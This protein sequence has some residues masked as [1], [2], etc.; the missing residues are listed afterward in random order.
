MLD[1]LLE[2]LRERFLLRPKARRMQLSFLL[3]QRQMPDMSTIDLKTCLILEMLSAGIPGAS[4]DY[5]S[6]GGLH[7]F[8]IS[9]EGLTYEL[10][11]IERLLNTSNLEDIRNALGLVID[12]VQT[13]AVPRRMKFGAMAARGAA[14]VDAS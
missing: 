7:R 13:R 10:S 8:L 9:S 6:S 5:E 4:F 11:F 3:Q 1:A 2:V 14:R 12:R